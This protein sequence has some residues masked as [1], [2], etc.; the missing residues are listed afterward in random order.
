MNGTHGL[1]SENRFSSRF[2]PAFP[3]V[4]LPSHSHRE[5]ASMYLYSLLD[6]I[7]LYAYTPKMFENASAHVTRIECCVVCRSLLCVSFFFSLLTLYASDGDEFCGWKR[8]NW[9]STTPCSGR[10]LQSSVQ[11]KTGICVYPTWKLRLRFVDNFHRRSITNDVDDDDETNGNHR[12]RMGSINFGVTVVP[13]TLHFE[14]F[15]CVLSSWADS[16]PSSFKTTTIK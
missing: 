5:S 10:S 16:H 6:A 4:Y 9:F 14:A 13:I 7:R 2:I 12:I 11:Y 8:V 1:Q 3:L 15:C